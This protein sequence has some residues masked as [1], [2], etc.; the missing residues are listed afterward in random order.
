MN[1]K[2]YLTQMTDQDLAAYW[3]QYKNQ[4]Q[5]KTAWSVLRTRL[6]GIVQKYGPPS[7]WNYTTG[8]QK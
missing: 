8:W 7:R 1:K 6:P 4:P 2:A 5:A 3:G